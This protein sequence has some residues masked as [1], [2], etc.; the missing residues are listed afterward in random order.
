MQRSCILPEHP[1]TQSDS[2]SGSLT[3]KLGGAD[4]GHNVI[5]SGEFAAALT[6][7]DEEKNKTN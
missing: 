6:K 4:F 5:T 3:G 7:L 2:R 1:S